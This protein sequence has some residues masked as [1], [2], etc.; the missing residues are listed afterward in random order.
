MEKDTTTMRLHEYLRGDLKAMEAMLEQLELAVRQLRSQF[1]MVYA[2]ADDLQVI[3][4]GDVAPGPD[5][6]ARS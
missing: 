4:E 2:V 1:S 3:E 6:E 5:E